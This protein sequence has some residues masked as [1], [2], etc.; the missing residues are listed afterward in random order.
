VVIFDPCSVLHSYLIRLPKVS[1]ARTSSLAGAMPQWL[2]DLYIASP[3]YNVNVVDGTCVEK[4]AVLAARLGD[5]PGVSECPAGDEAISSEFDAMV[6][7]YYA[8]QGSA[9]VR[10]DGWAASADPCSWYGV[11]CNQRNRVTGIDLDGN[12]LVGTFP[13][14]MLLLSQLKCVL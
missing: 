4:P 6:Q 7:V 8:L 3:S 11:T 1:F 12:N 2:V 14:E 10:A 5:P 9:W 13:S